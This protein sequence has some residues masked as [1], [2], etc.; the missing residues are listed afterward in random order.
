MTGCHLAD[1]FLYW[2]NPHSKLKTFHCKAKKIPDISLKYIRKRYPLSYIHHHLTV[3]IF[4]RRNV[5][6]WLITCSSF[7]AG[8]PKVAG[9]VSIQVLNAYSIYA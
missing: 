9:G 4:P 1:K 2:E 6:S 7:E 3:G 8:V 5:M